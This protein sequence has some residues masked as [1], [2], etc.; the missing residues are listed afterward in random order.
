MPKRSTVWQLLSVVEDWSLA[1][2]SGHCVHACFLDVSK[3]FDRVDHGLL[4]LKLEHVGI[5]V[6]SLQWFTDYLKGR[7]IMTVVSASVSTVP[8]VLS[9]VSQ[10]SVLGPLLFVIFFRDLLNS[11]RAL[12]VCPVRR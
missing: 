4:L 3:A 10:R 7:N 12:H 8:P 1:L 11:D 2:D 9:G 5:I 6:I